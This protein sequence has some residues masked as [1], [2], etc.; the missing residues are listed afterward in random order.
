L[1]QECLTNNLPSITVTQI[2]TSN[3]AKATTLISSKLITLTQHIQSLDLL[4]W[5]LWGLLNLLRESQ[6]IR[7]SWLRS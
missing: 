5:L 7:I 1:D 3:Q 6:L 2:R 4:L